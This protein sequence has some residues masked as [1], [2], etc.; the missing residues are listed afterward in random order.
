M[1]QIIKSGKTRKEA[2]DKAITELEEA[3]KGN[4]KEAI[5][6]KTKALAEASG[7]SWRVGVLTDAAMSGQVELEEIYAKRLRSIRP[8][9]GQVQAIRQLYKRHIVADAA[10]ILLYLGLSLLAPV[11]PALRYLLPVLLLVVGACT[12]I[13]AACLRVLAVFVHSIDYCSEGLE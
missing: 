4:D 11:G 2:I 13:V 1:E 7:K 12:L 8:T 10:G 5:E 9:K 6:S 3:M